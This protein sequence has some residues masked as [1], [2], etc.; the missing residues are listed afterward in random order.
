MVTSSG[1][2]EHRRPDRPVP[3]PDSDLMDV[4][5][6]TVRE[7]MRRID[8]AA[9]AVY[10]VAEGGT[11]LRPA[12]IAGNAPSLFTLPARM[13]L[14]QPYATAR[15]VASGTT[16]LLPDPDPAPSPQR[17]TRPYPYAA[18]AAPV[19]SGRRRF[20]TLT[21]LRLE[22]LGAYP[23][24]D[25]T[26]V[27]NIA[28]ETADALT[29]LTERGVPIT[30]GPQ[31]AVVPI[32]AGSTE[33]PGWG[34]PGV[35]GSS[36]VSLMFPLRLLSELL[37]QATTPGDVV[38]AAQECLMAPLHADALVLA[39]ADA[40]HLWVLGHSGRSSGLV[41][42]VH[43]AALSASTPLAQAARGRALFLSAESSPASPDAYDDPPRAEAFLPLIA[44]SR[45][46]D[47]A[48]AGQKNVVGV[49]C[50]S[51]PG[52]RDFPPEERATLSMM[53]ALLG[54]AVQ[55]VGLSEKQ[56]RRAEG[57]QR[58]LL[59][60]TL[61][62]LPRLTT[63]ARYRPATVAA[64]VGGDWYDA[65][66]VTDERIVLVV[67]DVEGHSVES[68]AVMS[69]VRTAVAAFASEG[70]RPATVI[71]RTA[72]LLGA[73]RTELL[74][75]C[76]VLALDTADGTAEVALAG[77]PEPLVLRPDGSTGRLE[78][79]TNV[80]LG[81][82]AQDAYRGR[83]HAL[84]PGTVLMLYSNGLIGGNAT[85]PCSSAQTLLDAGH[86]AGSA[87]L[88]QL[89]DRL[90]AERSDPQELR[91]DAVLL[92]ARFEE[93]VGTGPPRTAGLRIQRR[94][95]QGVKAV[96]NFVNDRLDAWGLSGVSES[97][98]LVASEIV[99]NAL[100]HA[101]SD[102]D[103]RLRAFPDHVRLEVRDSD[104]NPPVPSPLALEEEENAEAEH[105]RGLLIVEALA[106]GWHSFPNGRGKT[107]SLDLP[108][109]S[110]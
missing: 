24:A 15:A 81:V 64:R 108:L 2:G 8:A 97:L 50:L 47:L 14:D 90:V 56:R 30:P 26:V 94:D 62:E 77:H 12:L 19:L 95:V 82:R 38:A 43:G 103:V 104:S 32:G 105:G 85:D 7:T 21:V 96:R 25:R 6:A 40:T 53:A 54:A 65:I 23:R 63:T 73:L 20:G 98:R 36:G 61:P 88:E 79:P 5:Y 42:N 71:D 102:V 10:L 39:S 41:R 52:P 17:Y 67:G 9:A 83:E 87:D 28:A 46:A 84:P 92:L 76:C 59:P 60:S 93:T 37:N 86:R 1:T 58:R 18:L 99:T 69:Q 101:G 34:V 11:E 80:P 110:G 45:T 51:F 109:A 72:G 100:I 70:H 68:A 13:R 16:A 89:A 66:R 22:T 4:L 44:G 27:E 29:V 49:C 78:A 106:G 31:P 33:T 55:R 48:L 91:D 35:P 107:V 57:L 75:T 3:A 74:V